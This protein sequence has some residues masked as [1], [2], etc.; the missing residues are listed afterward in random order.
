MLN[1]EGSTSGFTILGIPLRAS[2]LDIL[3]ST[4]KEPCHHLFRSDP[5]VCFARHF[6]AGIF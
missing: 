6:L 4:D 5:F 1:P 3:V 2:A